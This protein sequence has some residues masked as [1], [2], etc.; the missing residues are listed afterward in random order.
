MHN[1][2]ESNSIYTLFNLAGVATAYVMLG[3]SIWLSDVPLSTKGF[4]GMGV[5]LLTL[6][7]VNLVKY[8]IDDRAKADRIRQ[9]EAA[10]DDKL[11]SEFVSEKAA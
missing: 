6:S 5:F 10:R 2:D 4:W 1:T 11:L 3:L 7:L 8:R 9:L